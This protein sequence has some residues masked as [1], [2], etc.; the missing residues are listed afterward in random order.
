MKKFALF[1]GFMGTLFVI[2][3]AFA[4]AGDIKTAS[5]NK[6]RKSV[7]DI[8]YGVPDSGTDNTTITVNGQN[9]NTGTG[10]Y[11]YRHGTVPQTAKLVAIEGSDAS[12]I[13]SGS[14]WRTTD[15]TISGVTV[16]NLAVTTTTGTGANAVTAP[17]ESIK[18]NKANVAV[19]QRDKL[20]IASSA[21]AVSN[22]ASG[23]E[24]GYVTTGNHANTPA[25]ASGGKVWM[26]IATCSNV[27]DP[28]TCTPS[29]N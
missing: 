21:A 7:Y 5:T 8:T 27:N 3:G 26:K 11:G 20:S 1:A 6:V 16:G 12:G 14:T 24:C 9:V 10:N 29:A 25:D 15:P 22:C 17:T 18:A 13:I 19:L 2:A 4:A 28:T 23:D